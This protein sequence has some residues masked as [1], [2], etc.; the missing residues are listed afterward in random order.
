VAEA[1]LIEA[2]DQVGHGGW[3]VW[4]SKNSDLSARTASRYVSWAREHDQIG[5]GAADLPR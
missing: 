3:G 2:K 4:L 1:M 5:R